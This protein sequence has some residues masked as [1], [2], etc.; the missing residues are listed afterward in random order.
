VAHT[1]Q[2]LLVVIIDREAYELTAA[3]IR[4]VVTTLRDSGS[5]PST[6]SGLTA[7]TVLERAQGALTDNTFT[8]SE[9]RAVF[10][11]LIRIQHRSGLTPAQR[12][13]H[14][15]LLERWEN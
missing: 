3:E 13:L 4:D 14:D 7:A 2:D 9:L 5:G 11:A 12:A 6:A 10:R 15:A 1:E 8:G